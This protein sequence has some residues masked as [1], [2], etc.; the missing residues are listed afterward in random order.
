MRKTAKPYRVVLLEFRIKILYSIK[1]WLTLAL[2]TTVLTGLT[3][4]KT[5]ENCLV[6]MDAFTQTTIVAVTLLSGKYSYLDILWNKCTSYRN[7]SGWVK[8][9]L[10]SLFYSMDMSSYFYFIA[11]HIMRM[12]LCSSVRCNYITFHEKVYFRVWTNEWEQTLHGLS[13]NIPDC[14]ANILSTLSHPLKIPFQQWTWCMIYTSGETLKWCFP[15][16]RIML[17][18]WWRARFVTKRIWTYI[19]II[20]LSF[21]IGL[22]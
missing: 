2:W 19:L 5:G 17:L 15:N 6:N 1:R 14:A 16:Q 8:S 10:Q 21:F 12:L 3:G 22:F 20:L 18:F 7:E 11:W 4:W 13:Q 9:S